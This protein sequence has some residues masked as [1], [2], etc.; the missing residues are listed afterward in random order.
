VHAVSLSVE[1][2]PKNTKKESLGLNKNFLLHCEKRNTS[3]EWLPGKHSF[4]IGHRRK[5][6]QKKSL[7]QSLW[8]S[9][10]KIFSSKSF[11]TTPTKK[12]NI[13]LFLFFFTDLSTAGPPAELKHI[14]PRRKRKQP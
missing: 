7:S 2:K 13:H 11:L 5:I 1:Q 10:R 3:A 14:T 9:F 6:N 8:H 12:L 4:S